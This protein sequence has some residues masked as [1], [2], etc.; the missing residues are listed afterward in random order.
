MPLE[1]F[2]QMTRKMFDLINVN[3]KTEI[4]N[5]ANKMTLDI[6]GKIAFGTN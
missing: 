5:L 1:L 2:G 6:I 3:G 4:Y